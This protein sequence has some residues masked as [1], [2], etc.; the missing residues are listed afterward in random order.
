MQPINKVKILERLADELGVEVK[1]NTSGEV[2]GV[3]KKLDNGYT[4][5]IT[6][7]QDLLG[8]KFVVDVEQEYHTQNGKSHC[9]VIEGMKASNGFDFCTFVAAFENS[10]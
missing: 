1:K 6:L 5:Y 9:L 2:I 4:V 10:R 3:E 8:S 7:V